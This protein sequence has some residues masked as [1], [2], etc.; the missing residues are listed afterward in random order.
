[1]INLAN[2]RIDSI[3]EQI[4]QAKADAIALNKQYWSLTEKANAAKWEGEQ[5]WK[6]FKKLKKE[7]QE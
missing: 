7:L 2:T 6:L 5:C 3:E 1:M 4:A